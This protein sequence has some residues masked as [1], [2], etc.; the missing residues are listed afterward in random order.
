MKNFIVLAAVLP[1]ML[2]FLLQFAVDQKNS[3][4]VGRFQEYVYTAKEQAKQEGC[5]TK[6]IQKELKQN[7]AAAFQISEDEVKIAATETR[8]YRVNG[9]SANGERGLIHYKVTVPLKTLMAGRRL[10][11]IK[12]EDNQGLYTIESCTASERL[13]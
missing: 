4:S 3:A 6:E 13:P 5:F 1:L 11:G 2:V 10:F 8:Q 12:E 7:V 9:F